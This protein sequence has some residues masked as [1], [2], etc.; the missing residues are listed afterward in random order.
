MPNPAS[1]YCL[2]LKGKLIKRQN[3]L[4]EYNDCLLPGGQVIE[5]WTLFRRDH[6]VKN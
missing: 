1:V 6:S 2:E 5:E 3:D 4:G